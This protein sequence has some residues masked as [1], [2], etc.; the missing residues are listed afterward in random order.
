NILLERTLLET[1]KYDK[2]NI[3]ELSPE[4]FTKEIEKHKYFLQ[5]IQEE[6]EADELEEERIKIQK[7]I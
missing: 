6:Y 7:N 2:D 4:E 5:H 1:N 3:I